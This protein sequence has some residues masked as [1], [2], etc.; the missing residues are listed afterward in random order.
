M[1]QAW[2]AALAAAVLL[3]DQ[4]AA[5][6]PTGLIDLSATQNVSM[7]NANEANATGIITRGIMG[8]LHSWSRNDAA[9]IGSGRE[10]FGD[11]MAELGLAVF[12]CFLAVLGIAAY[13][14]TAFKHDPVEA[15]TEAGVVQMVVL[16]LSAG[17]FVLGSF[18]PPEILV[19]MMGT[20]GN[21]LWMCR[22]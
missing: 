18:L 11:D 4:V 22:T 9:G 20:A 5:V 14:A 7:T 13:R 12:V 2:Y 16:G 3:T 21:V 1:P 17:V 15:G 19:F 8:L 6:Q 10:S